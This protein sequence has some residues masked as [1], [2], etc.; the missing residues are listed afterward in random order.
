LA[1]FLLGYLQNKPDWFS[2]EKC[3][4]I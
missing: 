3:V 4:F 2:E 1:A